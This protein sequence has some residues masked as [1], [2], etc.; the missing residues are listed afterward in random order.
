MKKLIYL[1]ESDFDWDEDGDVTNYIKCSDCPLARA[2]K[3]QLGIA[4]VG[5]GGAYNDGT[6]Y[7]DIYDEKWFFKGWDSD[8]ADA[9]ALAYKNGDKT[10]YY[11][12]ISTYKPK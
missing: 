6:G 1:Q 3:R 12:E 8:I 7:L 5:V 4:N 2:I 11:V 9:V 10:Q